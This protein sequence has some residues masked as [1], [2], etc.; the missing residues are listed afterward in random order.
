M[1][2]NPT[3]RV[4]LNLAENPNN[5]PPDPNM[6]PVLID[7]VPIQSMVFLQITAGHDMKTTVSLQFHAEITG[8]IG[9]KTVADMLKDR[10]A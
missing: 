7:G 10:E 1:S 8:N 4:M 3:N 2:D 5:E 9:G 6:A